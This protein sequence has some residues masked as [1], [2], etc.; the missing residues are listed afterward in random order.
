MLTEE[1]AP[2]SRPPRYCKAPTVASFDTLPSFTPPEDEASEVASDIS[3]LHVHKPKAVRRRRKQGRP[4]SP[5]WSTI[6]G[7]EV[8]DAVPPPNAR[9]AA[10][11]SAAPAS[12]L[13]GGALSEQSDGQTNILF[14]DVSDGGGAT[15]CADREAPASRAGGKSEEE[16]EQFHHT[17]RARTR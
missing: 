6:G 15:P 3:A 4:S 14:F 16:Y 7:D 13:G 2:V 5:S 17:V 8:F 12:A 1:C 11:P 9:G 10:V